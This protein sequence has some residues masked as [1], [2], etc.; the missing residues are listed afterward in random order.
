MLRVGGG[1][2]ARHSGERL[3][4]VSLQVPSVAHSSAVGA[5]RRWLPS[6]AGIGLRD[7]GFRAMIQQGNLE[8]QIRRRPLQRFGCRTFERRL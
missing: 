4:E 3:A 5:L 2:R 8:V 1:Q 6:A 7:S